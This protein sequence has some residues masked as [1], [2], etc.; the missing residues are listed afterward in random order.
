MNRV[1]EGLERVR[2]FIDD[3]VCFS[4]NG[5]EHVEDLTKF[6]ERLTTYDL[7]LAPKKAH[8]GVRAI[9]FLGHRVTAEGLAPDPGKVE[10][11]IKMPMPA[12]VS[13]LRSVLGGGDCHI[14][15]NLSR[16]WRPRPDP[17]IGC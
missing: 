6:F 17:S 14:I 1:C 5:T 15:E 7:K 13:Q 4:T 8:L 3:I 16:K 11:L 10:A 2:L 9:K 12:D